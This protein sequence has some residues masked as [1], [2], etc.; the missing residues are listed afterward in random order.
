MYRIGGFGYVRDYVGKWF[1]VAYG[2]GEYEWCV[3]GDIGVYDVICDEVLGD[4]GGDRVC[5]LYVVDRL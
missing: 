3:G 4:R 1:V 5:A 2:F